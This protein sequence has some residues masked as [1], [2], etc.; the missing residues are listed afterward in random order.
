MLYQYVANTS[1]RY[2]LTV[3]RRFPFVVVVKQL[4]LCEKP[5]GVKV[6]TKY[7]VGQKAKCQVFLP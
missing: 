2:I 4:E 7:K 5:S 1:K 6:H 3:V